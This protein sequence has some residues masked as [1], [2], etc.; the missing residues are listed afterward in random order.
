MLQFYIKNVYKN[1]FFRLVLIWFERNKRFL[2]MK[3]IRGE[4]TRPD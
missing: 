4:L 3:K 2:E 1:I